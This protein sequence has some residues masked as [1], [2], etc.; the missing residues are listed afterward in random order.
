MYIYIYTQYTY[1]YLSIEPSSEPMSFYKGILPSIIPIF[2]NI[3]THPTST[4]TCPWCGLGFSPAQPLNIHKCILHMQCLPGVDCKM[5]IFCLVKSHQIILLIRFLA[6]PTRFNDSLPDM[7][8]T[9][10]DLYVS[11]LS[12]VFPAE[13]HK[14][15]CNMERYWEI[16]HTIG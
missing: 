6:K 16:H 15:L 5:P 9:K 1:I 14:M 11:W 8:L 12:P 7:C 3:P 4:R 2:S 13:I 10:W